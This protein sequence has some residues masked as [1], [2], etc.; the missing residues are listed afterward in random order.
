LEAVGPNTVKLAEPLADQAVEVRV[1]PL[2]RATLDNHVAQL[3]LGPSALDM[4]PTRPS[5]ATHLAPLGDVDLHQLVHSFLKVELHESA[6][7]L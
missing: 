7:T 4:I 2:L 6:N 3:D 1:R 5:R